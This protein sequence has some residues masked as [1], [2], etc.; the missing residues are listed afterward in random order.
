VRLASP[1]KKF[2]KDGKPASD[3]A[4]R[5]VINEA[6]CEGCGDCS[7]QSNCLSV[8]PLE[9]EFGRKRQ[10]NQSLVQQG[11]F[12]VNG[13]CPSFVTV[14]GGK[15]KKPAKAKVE[16]GTALDVASLPAPALP[17]TTEPLN[18]LVTGIGGTGVITIGQIM[19]M[20]A[21]LEGK[22]CSVLDITGLAQKG[23]AV[24]SHV[25][26][27]DNAADLHSTVLVPAWRIW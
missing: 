27:A 10:I 11:L 2:D 26:L 16:Q 6:V 15:L 18:V 20:A 9:T 13:F 25:R 5:A 24:M 4:K 12:C 7:V 17:A 1:P 8:E 19:A 23:G 14:E 21:H 3:P 22:A